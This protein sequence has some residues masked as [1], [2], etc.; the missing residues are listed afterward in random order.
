MSRRWACFAPTLVLAGCGVS[1]APQKPSSDGMA[2]TEDSVTHA[3]APEPSTGGSAGTALPT[4]GSMSSPTGTSTSS[5]ATAPL[6]D[7]TSLDGNISCEAQTVR[8][9]A[10]IEGRTVD[11][12]FNVT[13]HSISSLSIGHQ[14]S[15]NGR[16]WVRVKVAGQP[17]E[18]VPIE[19]GRLMLP[20]P[21]PLAGVELCADRSGSLTRGVGT[22]TYEFRR[23]LPLRCPGEPV[24]GSL[25]LCEDCSS[26]SGTIDGLGFSQ[27]VSGRGAAANELAIS[28]S[29]GSAT[30]DT[31]DPS[32][33]A[34]AGVIK[35]G[36]LFSDPEGPLAGDVFCLEEGT[37]TRADASVSNA[38]AFQVTRLSRIGNCAT[39]ESVG[40]ATVC[41]KDPS[42]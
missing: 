32:L 17:E 3:T 31:D 7:D 8:V 19:R 14:L 40:S 35:G 27:A 41:V 28:W 42:I 29:G 21:D 5:T 24:E 38:F 13:S 25:S 34:A 18:T 22:A 33:D 36:L 11:E 4:T 15:S 9:R 23:L 39:S 20:S 26:L 6:D 2:G 12:V 37:F 16:V 1:D 10:T 30:L